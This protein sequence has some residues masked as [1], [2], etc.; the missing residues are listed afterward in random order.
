MQYRDT[1]WPPT[2][3]RQMQIDTIQ[4]KM[5]SSVMRLQ[6]EPSE[7]P[8]A[9]LR[10]RHRTATSIMKEHGS[11]SAKHCKRV[12]DWSAHLNRAQNQNS[13]AAILLKFRD[14]EWIDQ[15]RRDHSKGNLSLTNTRAAPGFVAM[16]WHDGVKLAAQR[17]VF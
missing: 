8:I 13:W 17:R 9:Y 5:T 14:G 7:N 4:R 10:R 1:R 12:T 3:L 2:S 6:P 11:W 15:Q 16:R